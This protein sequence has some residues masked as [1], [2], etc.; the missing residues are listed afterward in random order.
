MRTAR[1][2]ESSEEPLPGGVTHVSQLM[3][4]IVTRYRLMDEHCERVTTLP[5][6]IASP[7]DSLMTAAVS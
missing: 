3:S 2:E 6:N 5:I 7:T 1:P 4:E